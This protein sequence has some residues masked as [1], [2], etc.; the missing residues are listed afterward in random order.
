[1]SDLVGDIDRR[2]FKVFR[3]AY[4]T[5][6]LCDRV[7]FCRQLTLRKP[8]VEGG[9]HWIAECNLHVGITL[10][11]GASNATQ[12]PAT[13]AGT[14]QSVNLSVRRMSN[15]GAS[16]AIVAIAVGDV[17]EL[18]CPECAQFLS[19]AT[20]IASIVIGIGIGHRRDEP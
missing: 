9:A 8:V 3:H 19:E 10:L 7:A 12:S 4:L 16:R 18:I 13:A 6:T 17:V 5:D 2:A 20:G 15:F 1:I 11:K 14:S